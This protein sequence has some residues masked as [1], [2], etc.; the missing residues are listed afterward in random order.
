[1]W[2]KP[3]VQH[4]SSRKLGTNQKS[5]E[6]LVTRNIEQF[7]VYPQRL[8]VV[9]ISIR[10]PLF[11]IS[12]HWSISVRGF[13]CVLVRHYISVSVCVCGYMYVCDLLLYVWVRVCGGTVFARMCLVCVCVH[14]CVVSVY[15]YKRL[16]NLWSVCVCVCAR[17]RLRSVFCACVGTVFVRRCFVCVCG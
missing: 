11:T 12:V 8:R 15:I 4:L 2:D 1:M 10:G 9:T 3:L 14:V 7:T 17:V 6:T 13:C 5:I 16:G